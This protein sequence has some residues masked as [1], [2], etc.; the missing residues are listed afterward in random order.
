M[1][2]FEIDFSMGEN[3]QLKAVVVETYCCL[4]RQWLK[5]NELVVEARTVLRREQRALNLLVDP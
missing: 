4:W 1:C 3:G 2:I 5:A